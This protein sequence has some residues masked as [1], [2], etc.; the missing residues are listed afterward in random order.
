MKIKQTYDFY[1]S[2][3]TGT[4][5]NITI[6]EVTDALGFTAFV[7]HSED[8]KSTVEWQFEAGSD[9]I[10]CSIWDYKGSLEFNQLSVWMPSE[11][12]IRLFG[13]K[14]SSEKQY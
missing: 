5:N 10:P 6:D 2:H 8:G 14:Y 4:L 9:A 12:G 3:R 13:S 7:S 1:S 11:V